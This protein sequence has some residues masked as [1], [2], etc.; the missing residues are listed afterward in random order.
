MILNFYKI[1]ISR[2]KNKEKILNETC[3]IGGV[4]RAVDFGERNAGRGAA[5]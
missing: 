5:K 2:N 1:E 3:I 4:G